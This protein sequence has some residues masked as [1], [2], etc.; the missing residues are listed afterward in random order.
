MGKIREYEGDGIVVSYDAKRCI[1]A[2]ECVHG[3]PLVFDPAKRPWIDANGATPDR[4][5]E[6]IHACPTGALK[7]RRTDGGPA[8][9]EPAE[10]RIRC[11]PNG[12][13]Y[14]SGRLRI[15]SPDGEQLFEEQRVAL[16]RC[17]ASKNKPFCDNS[18]VEVGF[19]TD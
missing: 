15:E 19:A 5:A 3:L 1:H 11:E 16:C 13:L 7:Y 4:I 18:H 12:P 2:E 17:G 10:P 9:P 6:V 8:E 14:V